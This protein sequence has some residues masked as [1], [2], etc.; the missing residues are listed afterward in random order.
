MRL[1][2]VLTSLIPVNKGDGV[3]P[4]TKYG[5]SSEESQESQLPV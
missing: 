2:E 5:K 4:V 3:D 1:G